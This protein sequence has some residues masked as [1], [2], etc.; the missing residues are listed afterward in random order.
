MNTKLIA[1]ADRIVKLLGERA[2]T[3]IL[4][5]LC[6]IDIE[7]E[8]VQKLRMSLEE[9]NDFDECIAICRKTP[10]ESMFGEFALWKASDL[11]DTLEK[12]KTVHSLAMLGSSIE[13]CILH[14]MVNLAKTLEECIAVYA[15]L[16]V[17]SIDARMC[18]R[19]ISYFLKD[20]EKK[21]V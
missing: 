7:S 20:A 5:D 1:L 19:K 4:C 8:N 18:I 12:C 16:N 14:K 10:Q 6:I 9:T 3:N 21:E 13:K 17:N 2:K 15:L 11:A